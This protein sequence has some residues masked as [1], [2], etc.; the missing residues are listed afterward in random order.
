[1]EAVKP[2][3]LNKNNKG[4]TMRK[5]LTIAVAAI[6]LAAALPAT[7][8]I[9]GDW[10]GIGDGVCSPPPSYPQNIPIYAWQNWE[11]SIPN[12]ED[13]FSGTWY[14]ANGRHG[15]FRGKMIM[16]SITEVLCRGTWTW[17]DDSVDPPVK[18]KMG[19]FWMRFHKINLSCV[20]EWGTSY[21]N[22]GGTMEGGMVD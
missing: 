5:S 13:V 11:G 20:G 15:E 4:A 1:V 18:Y 9:A 6:L 19:R 14:D 3:P 17:I 22:E 2:P 16:S 7:A 8:Q 10:M 21:S 12:T